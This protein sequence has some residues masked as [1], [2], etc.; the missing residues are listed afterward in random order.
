MEGWSDQV[1]DTNKVEPTKWWRCSGGGKGGF[2]AE[3]AI[4]RYVAMMVKTSNIQDVL[5]C[6]ARDGVGGS[7]TC[8]N[9]CIDSTRLYYKRNEEF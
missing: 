2:L 7:G 4:V 3:G 6:T 9:A 1:S 8:D 5:Q